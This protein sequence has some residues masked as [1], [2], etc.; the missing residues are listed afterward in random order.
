MQGMAVRIA[1]VI[2]IFI[3]TSASGA[4]L[5]HAGRPLNQAVFGLH[6]LLAVAFVIVTG[7]LIYQARKPL[8]F[9]PRLAG[10][11]ALGLLLAAAVFASGALLSLEKPAGA[12]VLTLHKFVPAALAIL[13]AA[14]VYVS[15]VDKK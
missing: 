2:L 1:G 3:L 14:L 5:S 10:L 4:W 6:K 9:T 15:L 11:S 8:G 7:L 12:W 13:A